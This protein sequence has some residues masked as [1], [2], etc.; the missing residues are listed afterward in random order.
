MCGPN[1]LTSKS[2]FG[3]ICWH[4]S[5]TC[6]P[7][8]GLR[9]KIKNQRLTLKLVYYDMFYANIILQKKNILNQSMQPGN[10]LLSFHTNTKILLHNCFWNLVCS[11]SCIKLLTFLLVE[12]FFIKYVSYTSLNFTSA[13]DTKAIKWTQWTCYSSVKYLVFSL[14]K[15]EEKKNPVLSH[16]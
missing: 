14:R 5:K 7:F 10:Y 11:Q 1:N 12:T 16:Y 13:T 6:F 2:S 4:S 8:S 9:G 15:K 3:K